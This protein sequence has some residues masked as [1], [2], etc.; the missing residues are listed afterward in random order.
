MP[1]TMLSPLA[2][3]AYRLPVL[4]PL[5]TPLLLPLLLPLLWS[6]V[7][8]SAPLASTAAPFIPGSDAQVL[9]SVPARASDPRARE[10]A[11]LRSAW[12][13]RPQDFDTA[14][15]LAR[16]C[17]AAV[18]AEGD[19]RYVGCAQAA[20]KPWWTMAQPPVA[21]RVLRAQLLQFDHRFDEALA[22]LDLALREQPQAGEAW[23]WRVAILMV[24]ARYGEA[25]ASCEGLAPLATP[26]ITAAC[27]AQVDS[28]SGR[29]AAAATALRGA[30]SL[31]GAAADERLW[32]LTRLAET[33]ERRGE[34]AAAEAAF[35]EALALG[36]PDV[37]LQAAYGDFLL[38]RGRAAEVLTLLQGSGR[39][40][41]L[42]LRLALAA[43][44]AKDPRAA[45]WHDELAA[46]F[47]AAR[48]R[49][50]TSHLKEEARF[51]LTVRGDATAALPLA[52]RNWAE[53]REP[54]DARVLL[55]TALAARDA[56]AARPVLQWMQQS[57][58]E[59]VAL[60]ALAERVKGLK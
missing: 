57:G 42:L 34:F 32:A 8:V 29:A 23:A 14:L 10:L 38:D 53:Q 49:G 22:D 19:P 55:E 20:L 26:L 17:F 45:K 47:D 28:V 15:A 58:V 37:Y 59:S 31:P 13:A 25:R 50:D 27:R 2:R 16:A 9:A 52:R 56:A 33:E 40:D 39:A 48:Q 12:R 6:A 54:A 3:T 44:A 4:S 41:V 24:R 43:R 30:L 35:R 7:L 1:A 60:Q 5:L 51:L 46:R 11:A 21:A 36:R 18:A